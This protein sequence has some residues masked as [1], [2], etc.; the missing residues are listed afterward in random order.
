MSQ[1]I[2]FAEIVR[3]TSNIWKGDKNGKKAF[4]MLLSTMAMAGRRDKNSTDQRI[5][6]KWG[7]CYCLNN[8]DKRDWEGFWDYHI[9]QSKRQLNGQAKFTKGD[10]K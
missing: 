8:R 9:W 7:C 1:K 6:A 10:T 4:G 2:K 3:W 5:E